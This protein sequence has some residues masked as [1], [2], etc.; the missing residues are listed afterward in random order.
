M[1]QF[2]VEAV[3]GDDVTRKVC[4]TCGFVDYNNPK[5]VGNTM[6]FMPFKEGVPE[7]EQT[8]LFLRRG[9]E[10]AL[11]LWCWP[12]GFVEPRES[13]ADGTKRE[14]EEE[15]H[16]Q[17]AL[18]DLV[19][20]YLIPHVNQSLCY[21]E[22]IVLN[23]EQVKP[24]EEMPEARWMTWETVPWE[25]IAFPAASWSL[26]H[27]LLWRTRKQVMKHL[28]LTS[29]GERRHMLQ[30]EMKGDKTAWISSDLERLIAFHLPQTHLQESFVQW[31][32]TYKTPVDFLTSYQPFE[33]HEDTMAFYD[34]RTGNFE[35]RN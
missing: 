13:L 18:G 25:D 28:L 14:A 8:F 32:S 11:N 31:A 23:P 20:I 2:A 6:A 26:L 24:T 9:I 4:S 17:V 3:D 34:G 1:A 27:S 10:P 35:R 30:E 22:A 5:Y 15:C 16:A 12:G 19:G 21:T 29:E 7:I 33:A